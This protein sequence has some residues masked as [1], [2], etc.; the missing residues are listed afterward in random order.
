MANTTYGK[1]RALCADG[2]I[3]GF[4]LTTQSPDTWFSWHASVTIKGKTV[5]GFVAHDTLADDP[6]GTYSTVFGQFGS[7]THTTEDALIRFHAFKYRKNA[8]LLA[9][10]ME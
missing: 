7:P 1:G 9:E 8:G 5:T 4:R 3:R 6:R 2:K 10:V